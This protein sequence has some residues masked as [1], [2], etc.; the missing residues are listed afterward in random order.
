M[1]HYGYETNKCHLNQAG[2]AP[3]TKFVF[4]CKGEKIRTLCFK[5]SCT[6][7]GCYNK[8]TTSTHYSKQRMN[9]ESSTALESMSIEH[10][11]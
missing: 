2:F 11:R 9:L 7:K 3:P 4:F 8:S 1:R 10:L 5:L 6:N